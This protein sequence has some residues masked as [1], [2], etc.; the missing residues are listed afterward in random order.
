MFTHEI[1]QNLFGQ[2]VHGAPCAG[3]EMQHFFALRPF[4]QR[5]LAL[6][7]TLAMEQPFDIDLHDSSNTL[8]PLQIGRLRAT[9]DNVVQERPVHTGQRGNVGDVH[10]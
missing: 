2:A 5:R 9:A 1:G 4:I 6:N 10:A 7:V 3:H 8:E